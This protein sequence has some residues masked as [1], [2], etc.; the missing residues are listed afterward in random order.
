MKKHTEIRMHFIKISITGISRNTK[1]QKH[2]MQNSPFSTS[3][4]YNKAKIIGKKSIQIF[5]D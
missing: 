2:S 3:L 4:K 5:N 1:I